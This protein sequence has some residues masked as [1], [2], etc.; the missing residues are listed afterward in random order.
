MG[1]VELTAAEVR[2]HATAAIDANRPEVVGC[3]LAV[4]VDDWC[5][6]VQVQVLETHCL[7]HV[8][9]SAVGKV[10]SSS[11]HQLLALFAG[12]VDRRV[13]VQVLNVVERLHVVPEVHVSKDCCEADSD[14]ERECSVCVPH[15]VAVARLCPVGKEAT[16][17]G[18]AEAGEHH[19]PA[20]R[21][22][23]VVHGE[24]HDRVQCRKHEPWEEDVDA[25]GDQ[26][27]APPLA[28]GE[29]A[30]SLGGAHALHT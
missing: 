13:G 18:S 11:I 17:D 3:K 25:Y 23:L 7:L 4:T 8:Q 9:T 14:E 26:V 16:H 22:M 29:H 21:W 28:W 27:H 2:G 10:D 19:H 20:H 5:H 1:V 24:G 12:R 30:A 6:T 15:W